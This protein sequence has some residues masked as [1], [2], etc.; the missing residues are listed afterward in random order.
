MTELKK[1]VSRRCL[2]PHRGRRI[3]ASLEPGDLFAM[4]HERCRQ[5]EYISI[6]AVYD[7]AVKARVL[8]DR[9]AKRKAKK[10]NVK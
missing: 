4:R 6:A 7:Y 2:I 5:V 9:A 8:A 3:V 1:A 10:T